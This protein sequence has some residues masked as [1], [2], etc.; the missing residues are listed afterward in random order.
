MSQ[1][2]KDA[3][4]SFPWVLVATIVLAIL[5]ALSCRWYGYANGITQASCYAAMPNS[6]ICQ[7]M[8]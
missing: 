2:S 6:P 3:P 5:F 1:Q 8:P 7:V 4:G